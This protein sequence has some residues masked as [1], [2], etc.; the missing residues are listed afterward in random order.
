M[1]SLI[2]DYVLYNLW[3]NRRICSLLEK[4]GE[5]VADKEQSS[6]FP[7]LRKTLMHIWDAETIW[8][9]RMNGESSP[10]WPPHKDFKGSLGELCNG[11]LEQS[12]QLVRMVE[13]IED[14]ALFE[15]FFYTDIKGNAHSNVHWQTLMHCINHSTFHRGQLVTML[16]GVGMTELV[17]T[18]LIAY[19]RERS[20]V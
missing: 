5:A 6:S 1:K 12:G 2:L 14:N 3:A 13:Q 4:A 9:K 20:K 11:L 19:F 15:S 17:P 10:A 8:H 18:D 16:R 7:T